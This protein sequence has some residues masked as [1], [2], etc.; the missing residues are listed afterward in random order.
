MAMTAS[1]HSGSGR[2]VDARLGDRRVGLEDRL[3]LGRRDVLTAGDDRV[4]LAAGDGEAAAIVEGAEVAGA[5]RRAA[6]G[7]TVGPS[8]RISP[9]AASVHPR[10]EQRRAERRHLRARL[11]QAV[12]RRDRHAGVPRALEQRGRDRAAAGSAQRSAGGCAQARR[13]AAAGAWSGRARRAS[14]VVA[15]SSSR[16]RSASKRSWTI[17]VVP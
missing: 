9:S 8:T 6:P 17:A 12:G 7:A 4:R 15:P 16:T 14:P 5:K 1:P 2:A 10:A 3:D 11:G 13:R